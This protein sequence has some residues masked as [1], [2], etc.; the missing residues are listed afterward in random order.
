MWR[1]PLAVAQEDAFFETSCDEWDTEDE[2]AEAREFEEA[3]GADVR[4]RSQLSLYDLHACVSLC[5]VLFR[6]F[7]PC[8]ATLSRERGT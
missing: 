5:F 4:L 7:V 2:E 3:F 8:L 1:C 6:S